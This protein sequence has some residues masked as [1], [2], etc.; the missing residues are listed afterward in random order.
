MIFPIVLFVIMSLIYMSFYLHDTTLIKSIIDEA[1]VK[2]SMVFRHPSNFVTGEIDYDEING[3]S[4]TYSVFGDLTDEKEVLEK[5]LLERLNHG[6]YIVDVKQINIDVN[7]SKT[8]IKVEVNME[9]PLKQVRE[10]FGG[11]SIGKNIKSVAPMY[12]PAEYARRVEVI[13]DTSSKIK[14][15]DQLIEKLRKFI[16]VFK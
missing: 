12:Y 11:T 7:H 8:E 16:E 1:A 9:I 10:F 2:E 13:Y 6:L 3:R 4:I 14:G 5:Y 15:F